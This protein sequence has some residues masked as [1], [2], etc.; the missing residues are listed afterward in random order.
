MPQPILGAPQSEPNDP[1]AYYVEFNL[2]QQMNF[3]NCRIGNKEVMQPL[4]LVC[5]SNIRVK[6]V[7][8]FVFLYVRQHFKKLTKRNIELAYRRTTRI[9]QAGLGEAGQLAPPVHVVRTYEPLSHGQVHLTINDLVDRKI[10]Q[11]SKVDL[12]FKEAQNIPVSQPV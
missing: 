7:R 11:R 5:L 3:E 6:D 2:K 4:H 9:Q 1:S 10:W 8:K 12:G